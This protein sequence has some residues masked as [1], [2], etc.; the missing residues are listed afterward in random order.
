[1]MS[2]RKNCLTMG[3]GTFLFQKK[4]LK[5]NVIIWS[6]HIFFKDNFNRLLFY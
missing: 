5:A 3:N 1:M 4:S 6:L 2:N